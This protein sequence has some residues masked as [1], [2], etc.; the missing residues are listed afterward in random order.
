MR[1]KWIS[2]LLAAS[3]ALSPS[4]LFPGAAMALTE[5][6]D[7]GYSTYECEDGEVLGNA[8]VSTSFSGYTGDGS[9]VCGMVPVQG[10]TLSNVTVPEEGDYTVLIR[11]GQSNWSART[12]YVYANGNEADAQ[13]VVF[14]KLKSWGLWDQIP[15]TVHLNAGENTLTVASGAGDSGD[16]VLDNVAVSDAPMVMTQVPVPNGGFESGDTTNWT[17]D[18]LSNVGY[19]VDQ[20]DAFGGDYKFYFYTTSNFEG[21]LHQTVTGLPEGTYQVNATVKMSNGRQ[22]ASRMELSGYDGDAA[23]QVE[24]PYNGGYERYSSQVEVKDGQLTIAFY[25]LGNAH[26]SMQIDNVELWKIDSTAPSETYAIQVA[27]GQEA[28]LSAPAEAA[29]GETV[30]VSVSGLPAGKTV[31]AVKAVD[32]DGTAL[33]V[34]EVARDKTYSFVMP[35]KAVTLSVELTDISD[36]AKAIV[37]RDTVTRIEAEDYDEQAGVNVES[38]SDIGGGQNVGSIDAGDY[39]LY[40]NIYVED[41]GTYQ[42]RL[43]VASNNT[44]GGVEGSPDG[45]TIVTTAAPEGVVGTVPFTGAWQT[46]TD[47]YLDVPLDAG[48]Q[49]IRFN[50]THEGWNINYFDIQMGAKAVVT[51]EGVTKIEAED[52]D[53]QGGDPD[54]GDKA[55]IKT[56]PCGEDSTENIGSTDAGDYFYYD[57]I[58]VMEAGTY[59]FTL[60]VASN[61]T[62]G[63]VQG[64]PDGVSIVTTAAPDGVTASIPHT[65][66]WQSYTDVKV[67]VPLEAGRQKIR[68][69]VTHEG[70]NINY[71]T[72]ALPVEVPSYESVSICNRWNNQYLYDDNSGLLRYADEMPSES[73]DPFTWDFVPDDE[74]YYTIQNKA[75]GNYMVND[76]SGYVACVPELPDGD[77]GKWVLRTVDGYFKINSLADDALSIALENQD[78]EGRV[79]LTEAPD[80]WYSA[81][82]TLNSTR[83]DYDIYPDKIVDGAYTMTAEDGE[84]LYSSYENSTWRLTEDISELPQYTAENM[85]ISEALY[86]LTMQEVL[87][88]IFTEKSH[89]TGEPIEVFYTGANWPKV[90][91]RDTAMSVQYALAWAL[92]EQSGN[93]LLQKIQG[94]PREWTEDTGTGGS[95]PNSTDRIIMALA[96]WEIYLATGDTEFLETIYDVTAYTLEKDFHVNYDPNTGLFKGET[97]GLDHRSKTYPDW[98]D[99]GYF[100]DIM[101][102]KASGT[103]IEYAVAFKVLEQ[104]SEILGKDP[105]ET[106]KWA[107]HFEDLKQAINENFW[108]EDGGYYASWQYPEYMGNVLAEKTDVIATGYAIYYDIATPEMAERLMENYPLVKYGANTVYPQKRGKQF[109]AIYHN[110]GVWPGWEATLMEGAMK[111]G[112]HELAD[113]IMKSIMSAAAR[114]LSN[115]EVINYETGAGNN[116]HRQLWSVAGHMASFYRVLFGMT[117]ELDGIHFAPYV[118]DWMVGPFELSN[119]TYRDANLT[120]TVSGQ[121]DQV[122]SL[123]VNGEEMGADY[124][125]PA[126]ASGDYTIEIVVEDSGDHDSVNLKPENLAICPEPPEMQ[127]EDGVLTW[128]PDESYTYKLWTGTEYID[129]TGKDSYEIPQ[130]VYGSYSLVAVDEDGIAGELSEPIIWNPEGTYL[131]Y[132]AEDAAYNDGAFANSIQGYSGTGYVQDNRPNGGTDITFTVNVPKEGDYLVSALYNNG[133]NTTDGNYAAIRSVIVDGEDY[134]TMS[135]SITFENV[136]YRS[137]RMRMHL[138]EGEHT[139]TFSYNYGGNNYDQNMNINRNNLAM[140]QLILEN[141]R[142]EGSVTAEPQLLTVQWSGNAS[143]SV[144][145]NAEAIISTDAIYGAKVQPGEEL[146]FTFTPTKDGFSG[147]Q[148]NG[149]DIEFAADGCTYTFTMPGEGTTLRFTFTSV[150]KSILGIVLEE[151]NAVPQDVIDSL[152]PSAKEFFENALAKAQEVYDDAAA[153]EAEVKEAWSD[154]LDAMHL[155]EFEAGDKE[156]LLPLINIAEQLKD[157]LDQFKPGTTEGFEEALDAAKDVYAEENPLKADVDEAYDNLQAAIEKLEMCAD[158]SELQSLVDEANGLD[159]NLYIDDEAMAAFKTVLAEAEEL[160]LNADAGQAD[161]DAKAEALTRAMAALRKI[162]NKDELNKL[163]AEMEQKDLDGY[164][165]RSVAA[166]KAALSVAKTVAAGETADGQ[167]IAKAYTNLEAAANNLVKAEKPSTGNSGKGSTS[168]NV[169]NAYG[170]AGVVSAAQGVASQQAYVVSDTTV[171]FT[172]KRGS[173][174]CFKMTVVNG[175][176]MVPNFT[177]GNGEVLKTQFVAKIGNDYY[178]RVYATGTPGQSTGVYTTLPGQNAVKHCTVTIA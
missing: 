49:T 8:V 16:V 164:T 41:A 140:D 78:E 36:V 33:Q 84:E 138:T 147:A 133:G 104:A 85:P 14:P 152:V 88:N 94:D 28:T 110:R 47:V 108:V 170:A 154:L 19:G 24:I 172:L 51:P 116:A 4:Y 25:C 29:L 121:G 120:V 107:K 92:P 111:A 83:F 54:M 53:G 115:E 75:T 153:T 12:M 162:P 103:N 73:R 100:S 82:Y 119:Y 151:A 5:Q 45:V 3:M 44:D 58:L 27:D 26:T 157:M 127:L 174:Y 148:L 38:C 159:L 141:I 63:G 76:G 125:L 169:G 99:E 132:E 17:V 101:E 135:F 177:A 71:F 97:S 122:A 128:T 145:G 87:E 56:E 91:T 143:M 9:V 165:D 142:S 131:T 22:Q 80:S 37:S 102:S 39:M 32:A 79:E 70:W 171:N 42:F 173:A 160:L 117:Y 18:N 149:E 96:G 156:T 124:V 15:V 62:D 146:V 118:P 74:G 57:D 144:E 68:F 134:G 166:F 93:S 6:D 130:D 69:N 23:T 48:F 60:R 40:H 178:Y 20:P 106:E 77:T 46:Y 66:G 65:G 114:N 2:L 90:W 7:S 64:S 176:N 137:P 50:A 43:R 129:V 31:Q 30:T 10:V 98:M 163:I 86:N 161:V 126:N 150:D 158:M 21:R 89:I 34:V 67:L 11:Y 123:K 175:N 59:Q 155:L 167:A 72:I 52:F 112:N 168:A 105:A 81:H 113:E 61:N 139:I 55:G 136:F 13:Q 35:A 1:R 109:S 95:Y